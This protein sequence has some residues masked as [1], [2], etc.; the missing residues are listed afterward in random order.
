MKRL[1]LIVLGIGVAG[2]AQAATM[3]ELDA[4]G[5]GMAS[6]EEVLAVLPDMAEETFTLVDIDEDGLL[7]EDELIAGQEVGLIPAN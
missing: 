2:I 6:Y 3:A 4:D 1:T 7:S 5:D